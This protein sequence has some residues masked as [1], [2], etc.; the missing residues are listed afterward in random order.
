VIYAGTSQKGI[1][2]SSDCGA[3]WTKVNTGR[4]GAALDSGTP[5]L[6][7]IDPITADVLYADA[8]GGSNNNLF[9]STN[10]GVDW[11][12]LWAPDGVVAKAAGYPELLGIDPQNHLHLVANFHQNCNAPY[13]PV[14]FGEST[15]GG[16]TW[17]IVNG[18]SEL[19]GWAEDAA[20]IVVDATTFLLGSGWSPLYLT[21]DAGATWTKVAGSGGLRM[22]HENGWYYVGAAFSVQRSRDLIA[23]T[24]PP[25]TPGLVG[26]GLVS[27][28]ATLFASSRYG[29]NYEQAPVSDGATWS[30]LAA[31]TGLAGSDGSYSLAIDKS[32][33]I[34]YSANQGSGLYRMLLP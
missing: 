28:G 11:D 34:L 3:T 8:F 24:E 26:F 9:K 13:T 20:P 7:L 17:R 21:K 25:N 16:A 10:G 18:P 2:K 22:V 30:K 1:H 19:G 31:P 6:F 4:N 29:I 14:C 23:W 27:D 12:P 15:D 32:H 5:W 33:R